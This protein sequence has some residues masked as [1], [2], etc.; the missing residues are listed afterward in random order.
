MRRAVLF[1]VA[2]LLLP[3]L[4]ACN[5]PESDTPAEVDKG[6]RV[7]QMSPTFTLLSAAGGPVS[8][9]DFKGMPVLLYFS[10]GPG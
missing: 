10:M 3:L 9:S 5:R 1:S 2:L 7:G 4:A 8:L 6:L